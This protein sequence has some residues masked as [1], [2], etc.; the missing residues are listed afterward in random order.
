[1][2]KIIENKENMVVINKSKFIGIVNLVYTKE[3]ITKILSN[4]KEK[5]HDATHI[6]YAYIIDNN[7]KYS[8]DKEPT[9]TAGKPILEILEKNNLNYVLAVVVRYFGG[10]KLGS[11][12]LVRAYSNSIKEVISNNIKE[13]EHAYLIKIDENYNKNDEIKYLLKDSNI[14]KSEYTDKI[15]IELIIKKENLNKLS[16]INYKIIKEIII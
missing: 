14:I 8:D 7:K 3:E 10:I 16:N 4:L 6:C 12:G 13:I 9:G 11:G 15:N 2:K 5:Y 1:M